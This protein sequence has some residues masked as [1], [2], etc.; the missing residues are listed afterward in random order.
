MHVYTA[1][2]MYIHTHTC[3][4]MSVCTCIYV[5]VRNLLFKKRIEYKSSLQRCHYKKHFP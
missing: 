2:Y 1:I 3:V 4:Y 5:D